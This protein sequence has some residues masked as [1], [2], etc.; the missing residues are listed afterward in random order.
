ML[1][2]GW[3]QTASLP[4]WVPAMNDIATYSQEIP[5]SLQWPSS[6]MQTRC[7]LDFASETKCLCE[8]GIDTVKH[9]ETRL[10]FVFW[11]GFENLIVWGNYNLVKQKQWG[12][13]E[14]SAKDDTY[15]DLFA[16][17]FAIWIC[18]NLHLHL[19]FN[20][21]VK[22][23]ALELIQK[24]HVWNMHPHTDTGLGWMPNLRQW[25]KLAVGSVSEDETISL[26]IHLRWVKRALAVGTAN[27]HSTAQETKQFTSIKDI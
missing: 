26:P 19:H 25:G 5:R 6:Q 13:R 12:E 9:P 27:E 11:Q 18:H 2:S 22:T 1:W 14:R 16:A 23:F 10:P 7:L 20:C 8:T 24:K 3:D 4:W 21:P 15:Y 17:K